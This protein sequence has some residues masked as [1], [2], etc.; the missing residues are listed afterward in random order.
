MQGGDLCSGDIVPGTTDPLPQRAHLNPT[1][2]ADASRHIELANL[3]T[4]AGAGQPPLLHRPCCTGTPIRTVL[5]TLMGRF[6][7]HPGQR[8][9]EEV[10]AAQLL[11]PLAALLPAPCGDHA[12]VLGLCLVASVIR[13]SYPWCA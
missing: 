11:R 8:S 2:A 12:Q 5:R 9:L 4:A 13:H 6:Q 1:G 3:G 7:V 10:Q